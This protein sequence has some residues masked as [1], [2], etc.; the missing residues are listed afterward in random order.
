MREERYRMRGGEI[1]DEGE[2]SK[3]KRRMRGALQYKG[4][5]RGEER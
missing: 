5:K 3:G 1:Q 4:A 2:E